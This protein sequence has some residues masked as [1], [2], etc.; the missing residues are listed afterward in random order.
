MY[1]YVYRFAVDGVSLILIIA[2]TFPS[3]GKPKG[4]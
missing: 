1:V 3:F 4:L 2:P